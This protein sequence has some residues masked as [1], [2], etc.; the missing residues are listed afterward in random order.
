MTLIGHVGRLSHLDAHSMLGLESRRLAPDNLAFGAEGTLPENVSESGGRPQ[1]AASA[2]ARRPTAA[3]E[4]I[5]K[6]Y[7]TGGRE[8]PLTAP[9]TPHG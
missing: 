1:A 6:R 7:Q 2:A 5:R 4:N 8:E 3:R 9:S